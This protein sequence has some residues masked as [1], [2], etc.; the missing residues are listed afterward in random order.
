[1][2]DADEN[3]GSATAGRSPQ[4]AP[5]VFEHRFQCGPASR[6]QVAASPFGP[7]PGIEQAI[8]N[9]A[10]RLSLAEIGQTVRQGF[11]EIE[12]RIGTRSECTER[13]PSRSLAAQARDYS[14]LEQGRLSGARGSQDHERP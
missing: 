2:V 8:A 14:G 11:G 7:G 9:D 4:L 13:Q 6:R 3:G 12:Q 10:M 1:M 5:L